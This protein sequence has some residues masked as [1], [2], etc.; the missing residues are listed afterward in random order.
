MARAP[1]R[2]RARRPASVRTRRH[3][4]TSDSLLPGSYKR[5]F[6]PSVTTSWEAPARAATTGNPEE[7]ASS[8]ARPSVSVVEGKTRASAEA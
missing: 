8:I 4:A 7:S 5:P 1:S 6:S 3:A 2:S